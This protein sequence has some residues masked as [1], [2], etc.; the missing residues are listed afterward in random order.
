MLWHPKRKSV[1]LF[2][3]ANEFFSF[4]LFREKNARLFYST[5]HATHKIFQHTLPVGERICAVVKFIFQSVKFSLSILSW[6]QQHANHVLASGKIILPTRKIILATAQSILPTGK[7]ILA[8]AKSI[9]PTRKTILATAKSILPTGKT[10]LATGKIILPT[11]KIILATGKTILPTGKIILPTGKMIY[12]TVKII[13]TTQ[14][15]S[16]CAEKPFSAFFLFINQLKQTNYGTI[17]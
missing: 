6:Q 8:T 15:P 14:K 11:G 12:T 5:A 9:L 7:T 16:K 10:I 2:F 1:E 17:D 3:T 13:C 4:S